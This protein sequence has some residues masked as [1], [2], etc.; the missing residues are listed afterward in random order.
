MVD[1]E[2]IIFRISEIGKKF[3]GDKPNIGEL[4]FLN[5]FEIPDDFSEANGPWTVRELVGRYLLV[6]AVIDQGPDIPGVRSLLLKTTNKL[7]RKEVRIFHKPLSFFQ[8]FNISIDEILTTH[9]Y[10]KS[11]RSKEW[12]K[13]NNS[14]PENYNLIF[15]QSMSGIV[16]NKILPYAI[17]RW[18]TPLM[19]IHLLEKEN[20][21]AE[22]LLDY[23]ESFDSAEIM[24]SALK[25]HHRY[26]LGDSIGN[27]ACHL[28][29]KW[30]VHSFSVSR[31]SDEGWSPWSYE[32]PFDSNAGRV[33]FRTGFLVD[34][35]GIKRMEEDK[36][37]QNS[38]RYRD[39]KYIRV[40]NLRG[41]TVSLD[42]TT[43]ENYVEVATRHLKVNTRAPRKA[44]IQRIPNAVLLDSECGIGDFDDGLIYIGTTFCF[45]HD[46]P[47]CDEC[48]L[49]DICEANL[50][51]RELITG[52]HT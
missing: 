20:E 17:H 51:R 52:Y 7:Y 33:L 10:V 24:S 16:D 21:R 43:M 11:V 22:P 32:T 9:D 35:L 19:L 36:I 3:G 38:R 45:N 8:E 29:A 6:S 42:R 23:I 47:K 34:L 18:G 13:K 50:N 1:I 26:G 40:T 44:Q 39:K 2:E 25:K 27:K 12:A 14:N 15:T 49:Q 41:K 30:Y 46:K 28:F 48:P 4:E 37:I 31:R 5:R